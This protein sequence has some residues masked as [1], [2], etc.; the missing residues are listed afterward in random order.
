MTAKHI[1]VFPRHDAKLNHLYDLAYNLWCIWNF[2]AL[3]LFYRIDAQLFRKVRH[4]PV[5]FLHTLSKAK[6]NALT[7]DKEF[8]FELEEVWNKF[9]D[10][11]KYNSSLVKDLCDEQCNIEKDESIAYF[12][13]EFGLHESIPI[14]AGGLGI[15]AGDFLKGAQT[16][17]CLL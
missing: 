3:N 5:R 17:T 15:L 1:F 6:L 10:Y 4:N 8:L 14:Y 16:L 7:K 9:Q 2:D 12:S 13:M 11:L